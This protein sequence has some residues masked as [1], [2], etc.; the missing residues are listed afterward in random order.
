MDEFQ[1]GE[2]LARALQTLAHLHEPTGV[3]MLMAMESDPIYLGVDD[4]AA[5]LFTFNLA[6]GHRR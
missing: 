5:H 3:V 4:S 2:A 1:R 6:L